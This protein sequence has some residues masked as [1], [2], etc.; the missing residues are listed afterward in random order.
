M[1]GM[2][3]LFSVEDSGWRFGISFMH[4]LSAFFL[5]ASETKLFDLWQNTN[6]RILNEK[7]DLVPFRSQ[8]KVPQI[9]LSWLLQSRKSLYLASCAL[10]IVSMITH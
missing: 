6:A 2:E 1:V 10:S 4:S 5:V 9:S 3:G 8:G 7:V